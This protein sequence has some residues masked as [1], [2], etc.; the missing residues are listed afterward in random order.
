MTSQASKAAVAACVGV[1]FLAGL[2]TAAGPIKLRYKF[3]KGESLDY[4]MVM[5]QD[6]DITSEAM[7]GM[8]Q[9]ISMKM[10]IEMYQKTLE[11]KPKGAK[12]EIGFKKFDAEMEMGGNKMPIPGM[13]SMKKLRMTMDMSDRGEMGE[14]EL[15]NP[16]EV[17]QQA[18]QMAEQM[19]KS[20]N[21]NS[22]V[23]PDKALKPGD[24]WTFEQ[25]IP[26]ELPGA[27]DLKM[28]L[29]SKFKLVGI[30][31]VK[32]KMCAKV[33]A[34]VNLSLHGEASQGGVPLKADMEGSGSGEN[35]FAIKEGKMI[36]SEANFNV[37]GDVVASAQGQKVA[38]KLKMGVKLKMDLQ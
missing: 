26:A 25:D 9:K 12:V 15:V 4:R 13:E 35:L 29:K 10:I 23:F 20:M 6:M 21:Q 36:S 32:G 16:D 5:D 27:P 3:K 8:G 24:T 22:L 37:A 34:D 33:R 14:P 31:K 1:L 38:T 11:T 2:A 30:E 18:R 7:P 19:K 17:G 28:K